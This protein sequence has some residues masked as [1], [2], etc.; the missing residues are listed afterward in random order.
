MHR[1]KSGLA[2]ALLLLGTC[3]G[4]A[5]TPG[6]E[7]SLGGTSWRLIRFQGSD[8]TVLTPADPNKYAIAFGTDGRVAARV[9]CNRGMGAWK[10]PGKSQLELGPLALTRAICPPA[11]LNDRLVKDWTFI[12]SYILKDGHL[13]LALM[14]DGGIYEL[15]PLPGS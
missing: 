4:I 7:S 5:Q 1:L 15:E 9:D 6:A 8:D 14:A 2:A 3:A 10:S 13:F 11:S 12:R